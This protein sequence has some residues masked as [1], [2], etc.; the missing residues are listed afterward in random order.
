MLKRLTLV[1]IFMV[2]LLNVGCTSSKEE[3]ASNPEIASKEEETSNHETVS[4]EANKEITRTRII[5]DQNGREVEIP[6][7]IERI[8]TGRILPFPAV[9]YLATGSADEIIGIH[10]ASKSAAENSIL[11]KF[12]PEILNAKTSF[13]QG[14]EMNIEELYKLNPDIVFM[15]GDKGNKLED[16]E[17]KGITT[18]GIRT[19]S[20]A[21][22]NSIETLNSWL[23]LLGKMTNQEERASKII[24]YGRKVEKEI[25]EEVKVLKEEEKIKGLMIFRM[26][27]KKIEVSGK[28][29]FGNYW[30]KQT[31]AIDVAENDINIRADVD[32]EQIYKWNPEVIYITNF[33]DIM[34]EDLYNNR[35]EGQD[36][37][38]IKA[39]KDKKVYKIPLGIYRWFP[40]C[41]DSPLMLKWLAQKN[42]P[43]IFKDYKIEDEIKDY[44]NEFYDYTLTDEEIKS[45][46]NP[47]KE[48]SAGYK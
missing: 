39:V 45:I 48:A 9:W 10:P 40:P 42:Y 17:G 20:I 7:K 5:I 8:A 37:S 32:M 19:M 2:L 31:G 46:L 16:L 11:R 29:F 18:V 26:S 35:V 34:P 14:D 30:L 1:F 41:G 3:T 36:W 24:E 13:I 27:E 21:N 12:V 38:K 33:T 23:E 44:Y 25:S 47:V 6:E 22:G 43:K 15:Y 28:N 4:S